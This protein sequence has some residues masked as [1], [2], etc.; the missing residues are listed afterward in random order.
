MVMI[1]NDEEIDS[2]FESPCFAATIATANTQNLVRNE[3][4]W[5]EKV[6]SLQKSLEDKD[7]LIA[8]LKSE[9][10]ALKV[11]DVDL[12]CLAWNNYY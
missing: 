9:N 1:Y 3:S 10:S 5:Q 4:D 2:C 7:K 8:E 12:C 11:S 6:F